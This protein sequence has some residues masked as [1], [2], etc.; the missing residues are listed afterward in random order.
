MSDSDG[1][2]W[3]HMKRQG[4]LLTG[5]TVEEDGSYAPWR[6]ESG[7]SKDAAR[8]AKLMLVPAAGGEIWRIPYLQ[9]IVQRYD[10][11][12]EQLCLMLP[13][14]NMTVFIEGRG[15][16]ELDQLIEERR[17]KSVHVFDPDVHPPIGNEAAVVT[18]VRVEQS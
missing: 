3:E 8:V 10:P 13:S 1:A 5:D 18:A 2:F 16:A 7:Y 17:V 12:G 9:T 15:L 4:G 11:R 14:S 6:V